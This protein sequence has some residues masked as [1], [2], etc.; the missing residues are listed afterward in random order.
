M[1]EPHLGKSLTDRI[2]GAGFVFELSEDTGY[3]GNQLNAILR[4]I[5]DEV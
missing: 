2:M 1:L 3:L 5:K 4:A